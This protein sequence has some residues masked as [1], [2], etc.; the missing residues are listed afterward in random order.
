MKSINVLGGLSCQH[1]LTETARLQ[2]AFAWLWQNSNCLLCSWDGVIW[3]CTQP[4]RG[5]QLQTETLNQS[6]GCK[7]AEINTS[8]LRDKYLSSQI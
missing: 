3:K 4:V 8:V 2:R 7:Q 1:H 6:T 5:K